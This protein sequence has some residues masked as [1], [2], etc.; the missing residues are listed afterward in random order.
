[1]AHDSR[2]PCGIDFGELAL[3]HPPPAHA[4]VDLDVHG[5]PRR[6]VGARDRDIEPSLACELLLPGEERPLHEDAD[7]RK[8]A[9]ERL[10]LRG[11]GDAEGGGAGLDR[12]GSDVEG[13]VTVRVG[14]D[15]RPELGRRCDPHQPAHV[16]PQRV[17]V[18]DE[19]GPRRRFRTG[20][21]VAGGACSLTSIPPRNAHRLILISGPSP[22]WDT[23][24]SRPP[25]SPKPLTE[26]FVP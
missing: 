24:I 20:Q 23:L 26:T 6:D 3:L 13:A 15:D 1:M 7:V 9:A 22:R 10:P 11:R 17:E 14:L 12:G 8:P 2:H 25:N 16:A 4:R 5:Q 21:V 18:D 19:L